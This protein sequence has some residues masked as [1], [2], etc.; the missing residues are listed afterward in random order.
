MGIKDKSFILAQFINL[1]ICLGNF[2]FGTNKIQLL[3]KWIFKVWI[4]C[5]LNHLTKKD[6]L[7]DFVLEPL[8]QI[9]PFG[10]TGAQG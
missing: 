1:F 4:A 9:E 10:T 8:S 7:K 3:V 6:Y 5:R 2:I